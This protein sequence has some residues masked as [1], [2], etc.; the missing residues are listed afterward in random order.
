[1]VSNSANPFDLNGSFYRDN[2]FV[3]MNK[4]LLEKL[5]K[6]QSERARRDNVDT[7]RV[8][9]YSTLEEIARREPQNP[10]ELLEIKGIKEKKFA[11]YGK[12]ILVL[13]N[14]VSDNQDST[15][16]S[17]SSADSSMSN[18]IEK[19]DRIYE[20]EEYLDFLNLKLLEAEAKIKGEVSS[21]ENRG[22]YVFFGIKDKEGESLLNCFIWGNDYEISGVEL[23]EGM[24]VIIWGYPNVYKPSGRMSFQVKLIEVVG[25][26]ALKKAYDELK[27]K[28]ESEGLFAPER[29]KPIPDFSHKIGLITSHQGAAIGDFTSNLGSY[30]FQIKFYASRVEGKQAVFDLVKGINWFNRNMSE[31]DALVLVRGGGSLESLQAFNTE[32]LVREIAISKIPVLAGIGHEQD[33]TLAALAA[34]KMVSTP[35]GAAVELTR[36][37]D[38]AAGKVNEAER[39]LLGY[40]SEVFERFEQA[41]IKIHREAEKIGQ[42]I[43]YSRGKIVSFSKN[44]SASFLRLLSDIMDRIKNIENQLNLNNPERQLKLGYSLVSIGGKIVRSVKKVKVGEGVDIKMSDGKLKTKVMKIINQ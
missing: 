29:K 18:L 8:L 28:L 31:L 22:N 11:R 44:I 41:K 26:G 23:E 42:A 5:K 34:D 10:E 4:P 38:E 9:P 14:E 7:Y 35:T 43:L 16:P 32:V 3:V 24:E 17:A 13:V 2:I 20:V 40:L 39:N 33:V 36:S 30:G 12:E 19:E 6:W 37:W 27:R 15:F 1:L 25:E 21:V